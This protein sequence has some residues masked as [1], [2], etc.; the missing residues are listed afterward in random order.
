MQELAALAERA[1]EA[2]LRV[3]TPAERVSGGNRE[4]GV[5]VD[6]LEVE[7]WERVRGALEAAS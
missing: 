1:N 4:T 7:L 6:V 5:R 3:D 2:R